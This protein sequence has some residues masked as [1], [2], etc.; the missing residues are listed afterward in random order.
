[1]PWKDT[2]KMNE[3]IDFAMKSLITSNFRQLCL[4]HG[5]SPKTGYKWKDRFLNNGL[6]GLEDE[7]RRPQSH[8]DELSEAVVCEMVLLKQAHTPIGDRE[9]S[10]TSMSGAIPA[11]PRARAASSGCWSARG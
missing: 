4:E 3:K 6:A 1:M 10:G 2:L 9:R 11:R 8:P 7:S 5:I